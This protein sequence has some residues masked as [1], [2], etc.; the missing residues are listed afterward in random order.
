MVAVR[1][2]PDMRMAEAGAPF[3][4]RSRSE[5]KKPQDLIADF[6]RYDPPEKLNGDQLHEYCRSQQNDPYG[7]EPVYPL[8]PKGR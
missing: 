7:R 1:I 5:S 2:G 8:E 6:N 4:F 3:Y